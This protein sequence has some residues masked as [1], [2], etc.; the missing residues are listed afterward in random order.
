MFDTA[1]FLNDVH[2]WLHA[3]DRYDNWLAKQ[4]DL[5]TSQLSE[6]FTRKRKLSLQVA[7]GMAVLCN[8]NLNKYIRKQLEKENVQASRVASGTSNPPSSERSL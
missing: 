1:T 6:V 5:H 3:N 2:K 7:A 4:L 8:L